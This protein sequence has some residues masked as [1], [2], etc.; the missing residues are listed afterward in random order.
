M[1]AMAWACTA[2]I[3]S[4]LMPSLCIPVDTVRRMS[5][6]CQSTMPVAAS[7]FALALSHDL[8]ALPKTKGLSVNAWN[9]VEHCSHL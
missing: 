9:A 6:N 8:R 4:A 1:P 2:S 7:I 3:T 5:R